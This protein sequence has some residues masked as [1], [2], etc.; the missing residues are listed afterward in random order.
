MKKRPL[1]IVVA[2]LC[3]AI[4]GFGSVT[5]LLRELWLFGMALL[6]LLFM[7]GLWLPRTKPGTAAHA[8]WLG[9]S[10]GAFLALPTALAH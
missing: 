3:S 2:L 1:P 10:L 4:V 7:G 9:L 6:A 5:Y 8:C